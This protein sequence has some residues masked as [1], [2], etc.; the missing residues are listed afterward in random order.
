MFPVS[1]LEQAPTGSMTHRLRTLYLDANG[2]GRTVI[3][4]DTVLRGI[5]GQKSGAKPP[6]WLA[7][8][9]YVRALYAHLS[10]FYERLSYVVDW[11]EAFQQSPRLDVEVCNINNL[12]HFAKCLLRIRRYDLVVVSHVALGDD[13]STIRHV[14]PALA[15]RQ[16]P[17][18]VF[19][20]NEYD[21]L[22][23]K[24]AFMQEVGAE[25]VCSQLP[26]EAA[27]YLYRGVEEDRVLSTPHALNPRAYSPPAKEDRSIDIGFVGDIYWPFI[28]DQERSQLIWHFE[29]NGAR[30]GLRCDIR[31]GRSNRL[32]RDEWAKFLQGTKGMIGAE[33]GTYYLNDRGRLLTRARDY[34][35]KENRAASFEDVFERFYANADRR[36]SGKSVSSRHFEPIGAKT[37]QILLEGDYNGVLR[38]GEHYIPVKRDLSNVDEAV[39]E[40]KDGGRRRAIADQAYDYVMSGHTYA[41]RVAGVLATLF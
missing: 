37:C 2:F 22:D 1:R 39:R 7:R 31:A 4:A 26:L 34:N 38:A 9:P 14:A 27:R 16:C 40:F 19:V 29:K 5:F 10:D 33:S 30:Y 25:R 17:M 20:G 6:I 41:H 24:I 12:V 32:P 36:V 3:V 21:L 35:L 8:A 15:R 18:L 23:D 28:G 13:V 11:R